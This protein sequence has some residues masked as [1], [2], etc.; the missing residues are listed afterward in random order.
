MYTSTFYT[1]DSCTKAVVLKLKVYISQYNRQLSL[2]ILY[3]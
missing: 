1:N 2:K 3:L